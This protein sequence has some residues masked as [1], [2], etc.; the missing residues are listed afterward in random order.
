MWQNATILLN[1]KM[2]YLFFHR[3]CLKYQPHPL[4]SSQIINK[5]PETSVLKHI[6]ELYI[7]ELKFVKLF[8][9]YI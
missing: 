7:S 8:V 6:C 3:N 1:N 4:H 2:Y 5:L 9:Q